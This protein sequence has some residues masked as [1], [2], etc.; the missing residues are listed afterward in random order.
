MNF[1]EYIQQG[2]VFLDGGT[3][4]NLQEYGMEAGECPELWILNHPDEFVELQKNYILAGSD[5]LYAPTFTCNRIKLA[6][7]G[8]EEN[9]YEMTQKLVALSRRAI[10]ESRTTRKIYVAGDM[11]M[12]GEQ[13]SY[14]D[15]DF[16]R[17]D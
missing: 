12:T 2:F 4:S 7:Y 5:V 15:A 16:R 13:L 8:L 10:E 14:G 1:R 11:T 9:L 3:G 6:E 17:I